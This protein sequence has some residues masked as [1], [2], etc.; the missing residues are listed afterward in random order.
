VRVCEDF[1]FG[2]IMHHQEPSAH[3]FLRRVHGIARTVC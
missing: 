1:T 2:P 3:F